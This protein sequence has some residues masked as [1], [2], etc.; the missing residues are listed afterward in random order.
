MDFKSA[1]TAFFKNYI[2]FSGRS[3]RSEYWWPYLFI[4][5]VVIALSFLAGLLGNTIGGL[6]GIIL[7]VFYLAILIPSIAVGIRRLHDN[8]KSG[9]WF[10]LAF[11]PIASF[12]LLYL[13]V[14]KGTDGPNRFGSD[15]LGHSADT[16]N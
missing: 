9:W 10:L 16:F 12:Y 15:P 3:S 13:F 4:I 8:D 14:I 1:V 6:V 7:M 11:V 2:N 5:I